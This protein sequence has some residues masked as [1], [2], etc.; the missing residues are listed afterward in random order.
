MFTLGTSIACDM[1]KEL[2][3]V[4]S[5][6][7]TD[8]VAASKSKGVAPMKV[9]LA[10]EAHLMLECYITDYSKLMM[11]YKPLKVSKTEILSMQTSKEMEDII[12]E[13]PDVLTLSCGTIPS[14][15]EQLVKEHLLELKRKYEIYDYMYVGKLSPTK[16]EYGLVT[17]GGRK[18]SIEIQEND[19]KRI[20][21]LIKKLI[22]ITQ[23][24]L[25]ERALLMLQI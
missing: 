4:Q 9:L 2:N 8:V 14:P 25:V 20:A 22:D 1:N 12:N 6:K 24:D 5:S 19:F 10:I 17:R 13:L 18:A 16:F 15:L 11:P 7:S 21:E 3:I 23:E